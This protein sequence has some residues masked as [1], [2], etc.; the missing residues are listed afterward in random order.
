MVKSHFYILGYHKITIKNI[1][2]KCFICYNKKAQLQSAVEL[3][4]GLL[5]PIKHS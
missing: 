4:L 3:L 2:S 1:L 5:M